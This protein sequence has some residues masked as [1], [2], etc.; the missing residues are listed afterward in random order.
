MLRSLAL[1]A[2]LLALAG[3][4]SSPRSAAQSTPA[5][6]PAT[7]GAQAQVAAAPHPIGQLT[8]QTQVWECPK[9]GTDYDGPGQCAMDGAALVATKVSYICPADN[10]PVDHAGKCPRCNADARIERTAMAAQAPAKPN[11]N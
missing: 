2:L 10:Q 4:S 7:P 8:N 5:G 11:G 1:T 3:C 6:S 9:C